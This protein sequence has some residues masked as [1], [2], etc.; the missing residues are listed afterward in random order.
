MFESKKY[1]R[2]AELKKIQEEAK[3]E[4]SLIKEELIEDMKDRGSKTDKTVYG[5][6]SITTRKSYKYSNKVK[7]MADD[8][9]IKQQE[10]IEKGIA[11]VTE[12]NFITF[13][14]NKE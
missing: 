9:K 7:D 6:F 5:T 2:L 3:K 11:L 1:E 13:K 8:L 14:P 4:E 10:E 12:N